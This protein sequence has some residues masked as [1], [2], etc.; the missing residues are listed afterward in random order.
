MSE[1]KNPHEAPDTGHEWDGIR[2]LQNDPPRWW[3]V[4]FWVSPFFMAGY[5][6]LYPSIPLLSDYTR[7]VLGWTQVEEF[8]AGV[9]EIRAVRAPYEEK[10]AAMGVGVI[11]ADPEMNRYANIA[12]K[13]S[14]GDHCA[15]CH[16]AGG[17]GRPGFPALAD[18]DWLHGGTIDAIVSTITEGR[19]GNMP[20]Y[21][22]TLS[23]QEID[24]LLKYVGALSRGENHEPGRAVFM[25]ET[26]GA[27]DCAGCHGEDAKGMIEVGSANL[28]DPIWRF[29]GSPEGIRRTIV[30]G[31]NQEG[32]LTRKA[33]MPSFGGK[34][35]EDEIKKLAVKVWSLGGGRTDA[36]EG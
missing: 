1:K 28:T 32:P 13:V 5:F 36:S 15:P 19:E 33:V 24:E 9:E 11:L 4:G 34:L 31:V 23:A 20:A 27:A 35:A 21:G 30:H 22:E 29:E 2:E 12:A 18:D 14:F 7:G 17:E 10:V 8:R 16:G 3:M 26:A 6:L 25:G